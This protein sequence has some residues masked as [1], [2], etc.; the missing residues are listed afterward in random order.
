[1]SHIFVL[2]SVDESDIGGVK[3]GQKVNIT[4]DAFPGKT[5]TGSVVRIA[6]QGVNVSN[7]VTFEVKI[8]VISADKNLLKP[9]MTANVQVIEASKSNVVM[10][11]M[12]AR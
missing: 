1:M 10:I 9:Q 4:A 11:P 12:M 3:V 6:T 5:F 2:A 7:V 8:E